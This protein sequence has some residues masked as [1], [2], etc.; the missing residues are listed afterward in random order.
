MPLLI[1]GKETNEIESCRR[2][3]EVR[4]YANKELKVS[5]GSIEAV[6]E[7][8]DYA[9]LGKLKSFQYVSGIPGMAY[10]PFVDDEA[11]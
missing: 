2:L 4:R 5:R 3:E 6:K 8:N 9:T 11:R 1:P 10:N 7:Q